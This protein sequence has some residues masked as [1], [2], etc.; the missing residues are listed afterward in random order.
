[1]IE[2]QVSTHIAIANTGSSVTWRTRKIEKLSG[3]SGKVSSDTEARTETYMLVQSP[4]PYE[5]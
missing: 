2:T 1:M 4:D 5:H 3:D